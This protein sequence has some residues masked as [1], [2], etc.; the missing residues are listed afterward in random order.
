MFTGSY[1]PRDVRFLLKVVDLAPTPVAEKERLIQSGRRHYS[2]MIGPEGPPA[3]EYL[4]IFHEAMEREEGR[5]ARDLLILAGRVAGR[6]P[7]GEITLVSLARAGTPVGALLGRILRGHLR[8]DVVHYSVS[9]IRDRGIDEVA[10]EY[11][12]GRHAPGTVVFVD[13]WTGK[14]MIARELRRSVAR[15]NARHG[16]E[17][18]AGLFCVADLCGEAEGAATADDYLIPSSILGATVSGLVSRSILNADVV[19]PGDFHGCIFYNELIPHDLSRWFLDVVSEEV[20]R[21]T[22]AGEGIAEPLPGRELLRMRSERLLAEVRREFGIEDP[23]HVKPGIG[24]ATRVLLRRVPGALL[25][26]DPSTP[27]V[28]HLLHLARAKGVPVTTRPDLP[29]RAV[30]LI[31][32]GG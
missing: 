3:P 26:R 15:F 14:G 32:S 5:F 17:L 7:E 1:H 4:S 29:Y 13:G 24:E 23:N 12:L 27:E 30:A 25:L 19:G 22:R 28:A 6:I 21:Q 16:V 10:L 2:E 11:V 18:N 9:I 31:K 20:S 8:R